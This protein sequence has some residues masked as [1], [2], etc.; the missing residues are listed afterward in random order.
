MVILIRLPGLQPSENITIQDAITHRL[1]SGWTHRLSVQ[2]YLRSCFLGF[3]LDGSLEVRVSELGRRFNGPMVVDG[4]NLLQGNCYSLPTMTNYC[5]NT[6]L[7]NYNRIGSNNAV[8]EKGNSSNPIGP[9]SPN[10]V[11]RGKIPY[12][13]ISI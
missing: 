7:P 6:P 8:L 12:S 9:F 11:P 3:K 10:V 5:R 1:F 4:S 13:E 2:I